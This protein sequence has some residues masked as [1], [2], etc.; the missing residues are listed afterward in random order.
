M[1]TPSNSMLIDKLHKQ[2]ADIKLRLAEKQGAYVMALNAD[3]SFE[4]IKE[5]Y[6]EMKSLRKALK[7]LEAQVIISNYLAEY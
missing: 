6:A 3:E 2:I 4:K 1:E 5:L 7:Q